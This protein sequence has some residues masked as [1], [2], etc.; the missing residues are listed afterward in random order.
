MNAEVTNGLGEYVAIAN[1]TA[2]G[3]MILIVVVGFV[4]TIT[5][6]LPRAFS[7]VSELIHTSRA[8]EA[9]SR[10]EFFAA[11]DRQTAARA[12]AAKSGHDAAMRLADNVYDLTHEL[13]QQN[14]ERRAASNLQRPVAIGA[15]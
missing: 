9:A 4:W 7:L 3:A 13:R 15:G 14:E 1:L 12:E 11:L 10:S 8:A 5:R 2:V 6:G